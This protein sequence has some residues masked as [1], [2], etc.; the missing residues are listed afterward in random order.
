MSL[1]VV[2]LL[3][4]AATGAC[5]CAQG[6][7]EEYVEART[8][9]KFSKPHGFSL[10]WDLYAYVPWFE[11][12]QRVRSGGIGSDRISFTKD[13]DGLPIGV[14]GGTDIR[15]RFSWHDS[16]EIG[17]NPYF[18]RGFKDE[19]DDFTRWNGIIYPQHG[20]RLRRRHA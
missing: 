10:E 11:Q 2:M 15:M 6:M 14:F 8:T 12:Q 18:V 19:L 13:M 16:L 3:L 9:E 1:R 17:Y 4:V 5:L 7:S 20:H